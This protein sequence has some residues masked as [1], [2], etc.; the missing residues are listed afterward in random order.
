M[1]IQSVASVTDDPRLG[2]GPT[3]PGELPVVPDWQEPG[4]AD[5][6]YG[7]LLASLRGMLDHFAAARLDDATARAMT[8]EIDA[9]RDRLGDHIAGESDQQF[10]RR[11][12]LPAGGQ[13][14]VPVFAVDEADRDSMRGTVTFGRYFLGRNGAVH[15]GAIT[16]LFEALMGRLATS[17]GRTFARAAYTNVDFRAIT[18]VGREL[19]LRVWFVS[20]EG[21][22]RVLRADIRD[23]DVVCA[24]A[25][26][27]VI[28]LRAG[29]V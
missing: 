27:L 23:G 19:A 24:E 2:L 6:S 10:G 25:E 21:R 13:T 1:T 7:E 11:R 3:L 20:E 18:P 29:Q 4:A 16:S 14:M 9:L 5:D 28:E 17:G 22:K 15:G 12:D 8:V 26:G